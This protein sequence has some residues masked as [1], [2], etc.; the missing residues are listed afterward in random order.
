MR[1]DT[2]LTQT[3]KVSSRTRAK[4][5]IEQGLVKI[6]SRRAKPSDTVTERSDIQIEAHEDYVSMGKFKLEHAL[7][8]FHID[9]N[10][11]TVADLGA[12]TGG[13]TQVLLS[14][15]ARKVYAV[16]VGENQLAPLLRQNPRVFVLDRTNAR[17]LTKACFG[18]TID[19]VTG[20]LSFISLKLVLPAVYNILSKSGRALLL[21]KPQFEAGKKYLNKRGLVTDAGI[22]SKIVQEICAF[23]EDLG[24]ENLG[25]T[26]IPNGNT[27]KNTEYMI[28]L[29]K[30]D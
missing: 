27:I 18:E 14:H 9:L 22:R 21:I 23:S 16:D 1:I 28:Y 20:D 15:G 10:G 5:L 7:T 24:F 4:R 13:F 2:Y 30:A 3:G 19:F 8:Q 12:S 25:V 26:E 17:T 11:L 29:K 6:D